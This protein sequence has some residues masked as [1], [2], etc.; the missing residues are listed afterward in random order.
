MDEALQ[1]YN[2]VKAHYLSL[3]NRT[4]EGWQAVATDPR[5]F[6]RVWRH[7]LQLPPSDKPPEY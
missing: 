1:T 5:K 3:P 4:V 2:A 6:N 7:L